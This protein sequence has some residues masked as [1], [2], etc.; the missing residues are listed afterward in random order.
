MKRNGL[1]CFTGSGILAGL[2]TLLVVTGISLARGGILFSPGALND[3]TGPPLGGVSSHAQ[4]G[5]E[6]RLC[7]APFWS[8]DRMSDRCMD[9]HTAIAL[10]QVDP[11][12][13]HGILL[14]GNPAPAWLVDLK[15]H[16]RTVEGAFA[17][18]GGQEGSASAEGASTGRSCWT[19]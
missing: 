5:G 9:C 16:D 6:C 8:F 12:S 11:A 1:G 4:T 10:E 2:L 14:Q 15:P 17:L 18:E 19:R 7:H 3:Q 13:L